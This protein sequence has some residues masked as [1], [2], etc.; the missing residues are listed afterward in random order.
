M[1]ICYRVPHPQN[2][3]S[4]ITIIPKQ[5]SYQYQ[6]GNI[7][8]VSVNTSLNCSAAAWKTCSLKLNLLS[9]LASTKNKP[10]LTLHHTLVYT[11]D[12]F[13]AVVQ[14]VFVGC[15]AF[16]AKPQVQCALFLALASD[17]FTIC[18]NSASSR[19]G[20]SAW[21]HTSCHS[22]MSNRRSQA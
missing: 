17:E 2:A 10:R 22:G 18:A 13:G 5:N 21:H 3:T 8:Q 20:G 4:F 19:W 12:H 15:H 9:C 14:E 6:L 11:L 7:N 1:C 16:L